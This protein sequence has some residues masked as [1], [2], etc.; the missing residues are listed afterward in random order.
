MIDFGRN[1]IENQIWYL[2]QVILNL[3][4][5]NGGIGYW[6]EG[7]FYYQIK[8]MRFTQ[9][10]LL[11]SL[12]VYL[13]VCMD[14][15]IVLWPDVPKVKYDIGTVEVLNTKNLKNYKILPELNW[16]YQVFLNLIIELSTSHWI[17]SPNDIPNLINWRYKID[18]LYFVRMSLKEKDDEILSE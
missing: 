5:G 15:W 14:A 2:D 7:F 17:V 18:G 8:N 12:S 13:I 6:N 11:C 3:I 10:M 4:N 9:G 16:K 1:R